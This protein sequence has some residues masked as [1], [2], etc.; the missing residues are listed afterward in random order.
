MADGHRSAN[1]NLWTER[2]LPTLRELDDA[3][4]DRPVLL[5]QGFNGRR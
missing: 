5:Y 3:V 1:P 2:R 4:A